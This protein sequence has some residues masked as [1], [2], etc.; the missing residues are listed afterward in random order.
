MTSLVIIAVV[1]LLIGA[2]ALSIYKAFQSPKFVTR[3]TRRAA[4]EVIKAAVPVVTEPLDPETEKQV[5]KDYR[6]GHGD[7]YWRKRSG[8]PPKG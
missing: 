5:Q 3:L 4:R 2:A 7:D 1:L 6:T 8:A